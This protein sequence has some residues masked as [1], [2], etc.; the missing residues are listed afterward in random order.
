MASLFH[1]HID[2][3]VTWDENVLD[4]I[5]KLVDILRRESECVY[6]HCW[7]GHG[8]TGTI[9]ALLLAYMYNLDSDR[10]LHLT[11]AFHGQRVA[12]RSCSPQ[13]SAQ[14]RQVE[15]L[16]PRLK[17]KEAISL[18]AKDTCESESK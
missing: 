6:V 13:T 4:F 2:S 1:S 17:E 14:I 3:F 10:A 7:R 12:S 9:I 16:V 15:R 8:R 5:P 18:E 11:G